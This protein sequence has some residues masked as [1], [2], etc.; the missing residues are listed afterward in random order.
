MASAQE[1]ESHRDDWD[2]T[3]YLGWR[4]YASIPTWTNS[5]SSL[6]AAEAL[7]LKISYHETSLKWSQRLFQST[8]K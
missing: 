7:S 5:Q 2:W 6:G 8:Q 1:A 3:W 4:K